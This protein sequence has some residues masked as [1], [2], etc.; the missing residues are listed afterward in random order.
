M[1]QTPFRAFR[2]SCFDCRTF[3]LSTGHGAGLNTKDASSIMKHL[4]SH[5][6]A[7]ATT[8]VFVAGCGSSS[9][10]DMVPIR[11]EVT[12]NGQ[13]LTVGSVIYMPV[14]ATGRQA[15]GKIQPDG[16]FQLTTREAN[17]GAL[18]GEYKIVVHAVKAPWE[19]AP[20]REEME[21]R[22]RRPVVMTSLVPE[23]YAN[24]ETSG[25]RDNV[26]SSHSGFAKFEL[27]N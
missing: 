22:G 6:V 20:S 21:K 16:S 12:F 11:G 14:G 25:L 26:D 17:D 13:P 19:E 3:L 7:L 15:T 24:P 9:E 23:R 2:A 27:T 10:L 5:W 4:F 8:I 18:A 1:L